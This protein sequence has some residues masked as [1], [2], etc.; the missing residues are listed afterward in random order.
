MEGRR[1]VMHNGRLLAAGVIGVLAVVY[2]LLISFL[3]MLLFAVGAAYAQT[4]YVERIEITEFGIYTVDREIKGRDSYGVTLGIGTNVQHRETKKNFPA[5]IG[6]SFGFG[7]A[8][9]GKPDGA[10]V[11]LRRVVVFPP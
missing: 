11:N 10:A 5:Q 8:V 3:P 7:Y 6:T 1:T 2:Q 9:I 4:P